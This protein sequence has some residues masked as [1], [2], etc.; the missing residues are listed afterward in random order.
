MDSR[1]VL[2]ILGKS[3]HWRLYYNEGTDW[4]KKLD[5]LDIGQ[6]C[7]EFSWRYPDKRLKI[8]TER[9][10]SQYRLSGK[11]DVK[12]FVMNVVPLDSNV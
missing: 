3:S 10:T 2:D 6:I 4:I 5:V 11:Q 1:K 7:A 8:R 9:S 12:Q